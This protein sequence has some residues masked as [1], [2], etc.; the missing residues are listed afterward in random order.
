MEKKDNKNVIGVDIGGTHITAC[1]VDVNSDKILSK[2]KVEADIDNKAEAD[3]IINKW[4]SVIEKCF[5][6]TE[7]CSNIVCVAIPGPFDYANGIGLYEGNDKYPLLKDVNIKQKLE[8]SLSKYDIEVRFVNDALAFAISEAN[9]AEAKAISKTIVLT[10]GT[11]FGSAFMDNGLPVLEGETVP[12]HGCLW[13]IPFKSGI[14][15]DYFSTRWFETSYYHVSGVEIEGVKML[16]NLAQKDIVAKSVFEKMGTNLAEF[17]HPHIK[18]F[19]AEQIILG[20]NIAK[21]NELFLPSFVEKLKEFEIEV[22]ILITKHFQDSAI[23]GVTMLADDSYYEKIKPM[24][25]NM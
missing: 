6:K 23:I 22:K 21:A 11:G 18:Q 15:D 1:A 5:N 10:L 8:Q 20:G 25:K 9:T 17:L 16:N 13:Y 19:G 4:S 2:T 24:L 3:V 12:E 14:A 7:N